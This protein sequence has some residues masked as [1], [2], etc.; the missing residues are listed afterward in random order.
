MLR[1]GS[2]VP[3]RRADGAPRRIH[4][5]N[6]GQGSHTQD[7]GVLDGL[8]VDF[9]LQQG[10]QQVVPGVLLAALHFGHEVLD[11]TEG[12]L[13]AD[14]LVIGELEHGPDPAGER[15]GQFGGYAQDGGDDPDRDLLRVVR[16][17]ISPA[18]GD[19]AVDESGAQLACHRLVALHLGVGE[20][21]QQKPA[22]K[23]VQRRIGGDRRHAI[24]QHRLLGLLAGEG[25]D[26]DVE[27]TEVPDVVGEVHDVLVLG[28]QPRASPSVGVGDRA[29]RPQLVPDAERV[30]DVG[31]AEDIEVRGP[32]VDR[33]YVG[34]RSPHNSEATEHRLMFHCCTASVTVERS[35]PVRRSVLRL[36]TAPPPS[37]TTTRPRPGRQWRRRSRRGWRT[38]WAT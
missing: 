27:R 12:P 9:G 10:A 11:E 4:P 33:A 23:R 17:C 36:P 21:R 28:G 5:G 16:C 32:L 37:C 26:G 31:R 25:N 7:D 18:V 19:E 2:Q 15:V 13:A 3:Q 35:R 6:E 20:P 22:G 38:P 8:A 29:G 24:G 1:M 14:L 34:H 30:V